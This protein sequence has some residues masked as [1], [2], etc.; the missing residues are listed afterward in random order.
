M[1]AHG[2]DPLLVNDFGFWW[3]ADTL[4]CVRLKRYVPDSDGNIA[5]VVRLL[6]A[7][8]LSFRL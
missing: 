2:D 8:V 5:S 1:V 3:M 6:V 7:L 4:A